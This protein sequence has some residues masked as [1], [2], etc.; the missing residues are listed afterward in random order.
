M[1]THVT[2][3]GVIYE[4]ALPEEEARRR[5]AGIVRKLYPA[6]LELRADARK[7]EEAAE[8]EATS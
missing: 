3:S 5:V 2:E 7:A 1:F 4:V 8:R 6:F